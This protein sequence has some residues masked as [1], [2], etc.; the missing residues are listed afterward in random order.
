[1]S[2]FNARLIA[3]RLCGGE[4]LMV[5]SKEDEI[6]I[7][8]NNVY[9][10]TITGKGI[11]WCDSTFYNS[12]NLYVVSNGIKILGYFEH[13][14]TSKNSKKLTL[15]WLAKYNN[16]PVF[17]NSG[18]DSFYTTSPS[19]FGGI[20]VYKNKC[21]IAKDIIDKGIKVEEL[22]KKTVYGSDEWRKLDE[23]LQVIYLQLHSLFYYPNLLEENNDKS[24]L[25]QCRL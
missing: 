11:Y 23:F 13:I 8:N 12:N 21:K 9:T 18:G 22:M 6:T 17:V 14:K 10:F 25:S 24:I 15:R 19:I 4:I 2:E 20:D 16:A 1:M 5:N 3:C 7:K